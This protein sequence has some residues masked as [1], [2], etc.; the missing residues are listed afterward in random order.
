MKEKNITN[1]KPIWLILSG[2]AT[3]G[4][5]YGVYYLLTNN[6]EFPSFLTKNTSKNGFCKYSGFPLRLGSCGDEVTVLQK[7]LNSKI[8]PPRVPLKID[9]KFG[10]STKESLLQIEKLSSVSQAAFNQFKLQFNPFL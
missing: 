6:S 5:A 3:I 2:I 4:F 8:S 10:N 9:G 7:Y 1:M